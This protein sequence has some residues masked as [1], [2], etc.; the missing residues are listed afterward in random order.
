MSI[1]RFLPEL[2]PEAELIFGLVRPAGNPPATLPVLR[3]ARW[4]RLLHIAS[5]ENALIAL[6]TRLGAD[7]DAVPVE[8]ERIVAILS[9]DRAHR[10]R[11][12][13]ERLEQ[14]L[15]A[16]NSAGIDV[17]LLKGAALACTVYGSFVARPMRDVDLLVRGAQ[18]ND[19]R[20]VLLELGW[21]SDPDV[22]GDHL[23]GAHQHLP[24]L[25]DA[26]TNGAWL[27]IHRSLLATGHPFRFTEDL[28][29]E[30]SQSVF[31]GKARARVMHPA[32]HGAYIAIHFAW[33]HKLRTGAWHAFRD[34]DAL[35]TSGALDWETLADTAQQWGAKSCCYWTLELGQYLSQLPVPSEV[36]RR[37]QPAMPELLRRLLTRHFLNDLLRD[38]RGCPSVR[39]GKLLWSVAMQPRREAHGAIRPWL[40]ARELTAAFTDKERQAEQNASDSALVRA[41]RT[42]QY[43]TDLLA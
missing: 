15:A 16:L 42:T 21:E 28:I 18:A 39:L 24:P 19:A 20:A 6:R 3:P 33:S 10:M 35:V 34:L 27:E 13:Q 36:L 11:V 31:V 30:A 7:S 38:G 1:P 14:S 29:W 5:E 37:L 25:R 26:A 12:M 41:R 17:L 40:L 22:P 8:L 23:Y 2:D 4:P 43:L 32:H 9:L